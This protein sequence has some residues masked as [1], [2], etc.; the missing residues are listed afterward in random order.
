MVNRSNVISNETSEQHVIEDYR[1]KV[2]SEFVS[3]QERAQNE[4]AHHQEIPTPQAPIQE[5]KKEELK[6]EK[7]EEQ[8]VAFQPSFVEDLLKKTDEMSNNIIKLQM[9]IE[10]QES[11]FNNRLASELEN[12][13][14]KYTKEGLEEARAEF[15]K[16]L[17]ALKDKYL[18]SVAKLEEAC[19]NLDNFIT[20]NE[21]E[22]ADTA[23]DIAKEVILKELEEDSTK[24]AYAL[25]KDLMDELKGASELELKVNAE[26]F[27]YLK[28][29]FHQDSRIKVSLDDAISK[30]SVVIL[31]NAGNIESNLNSRLN[32][33]KKMI[34]ND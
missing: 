33:I 12:A 17:G 1:F 14:E 16:E 27:D 10:S 5:E 19:A 8:G 13:K 29:Q 34:H 28:E 9:Q 18:K 23:I 24:I 7:A 22:L 30:G 32:K 4:Q 11:E 3:E 2:I 21:K 25:A 31:S 6:E 20:K 26:D 15:E